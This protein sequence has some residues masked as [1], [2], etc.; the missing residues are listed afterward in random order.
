MLTRRI[1]KRLDVSAIGLGCMG[2]SGWYGSAD[3]ME[4]IA[5][6]RRALELGVTLVDTADVYGI[7]FGDNE[8][9]VGCAI[10]G[11]RDQV[12]LATKFG[13]R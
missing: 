12:T 8:R 4:S 1:G 10:T 3:D 9:L 13:R 11:R 2:M 6:I 5:T 7:G